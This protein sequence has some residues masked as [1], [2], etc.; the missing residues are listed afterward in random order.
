MVLLLLGSPN[1]SDAQLDL[2]LEPATGKIWWVCVA[3]RG[4]CRLSKATDKTSIQRR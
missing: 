3:E 1:C 2:K 4:A